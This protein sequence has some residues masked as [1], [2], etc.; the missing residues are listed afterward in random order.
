[1][2][3]RSR[4]GSGLVLWYALSSNFRKA[5]GT[6]VINGDTQGTLTVTGS[7]SA[8]NVVALIIA[9][10]NALNGQDRSSNTILNYL[11]SASAST[12]A[13]DT[14]SESFSTAQSSETF[15]DRLV[16]VTQ[17]DLMAVVEPLVAARIERDVKPYITEYYSV[18]SSNLGWSAYPFAATFANP[19]PGTSGSGTTRAAHRRDYLPR[20]TSD[21]ALELPRPLAPLDRRELRHGAEGGVGEGLS[22]LDLFAEELRLAQAQLSSITG[23][24]SSDDLLGVIFSRFCIGK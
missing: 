14:A 12:T 13:T 3:F 22:G 17:A 1:M 21:P 5:S 6:T 16:I 18:D 24:F 11:E 8:S 4:D 7:T 10:G 20:M 23:E 15:N 19:T 2:L 9:P